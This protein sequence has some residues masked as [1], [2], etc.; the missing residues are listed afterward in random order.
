MADLNDPTLLQDQDFQAVLNAFLAAYRPFLEKESSLAASAAALIKESQA[1]PPTCDD[2]INTAVALFERFYTKDVALRVLPDEGRQVLGNPDQWEWCYRRILC[3]L[4]FG[5]L[6]CRGPRTF[7]GFAYYLYQ[8]WRC[9]RQALGQPVSVPP[10]VD[11]Q[12]DFSTLVKILAAAYAPSIQDQVKDLEYPIDIPKEIVA[13]KIDCTVDNDATTSV[14]Q[15]LCTPEASRALFGKGFEQIGNPV[16]A[17]NCCC[18]CVAALEFGCCLGRAKT[19]LEALRCLE[20]FFLNLRRCFQ[21]LIAIIDTPPACSSLTFVAA[22]SNLGGIEIDGTAAG[23]AFTSYTLSYSAGGPIINTAVVYPDCTRPPVNPS[24]ATPVNGGVLG[25]LDVDLLPPATTTVTVYLDVYGSG[26]LHL[27]VSAVYNLA[28]NAIQIT[29]VATVAATVAQDPFNPSPSIIKMVQNVSNPAFEQSVGGSISVT[30]SAYTFGCGN[31]MTQYQLAEFGPATG[32]IPLPTPSP[33]PTALGGTPLI[34]PVIYDN[35][36]AHPWSSG[37]F[38]GPA[39]PNIILNGDIVAQWSTESCLLPSPHTIPKISSNLKWA[40][41][42]SGRYVIFL[43]VDEGP[44]PSLMPVSPAGEDQVVVWIDNYPTVGAIT[45]VGNVVGCGDLHLK[46]YVGTTAAIKGIAW[47][48][49]IDVTATQQLPNDNFG[50]Y[51]LSYQKNGGSMRPFLASDYTPNGAPAGTAPTVRV[52][53][54]WQAAPPT[55]AQASL[56]ASWD[57]VTALDGGP[58]PDPNNPCVATN[59][60]QLPRG[61]RCAYVIEL[62]VGDTTWVGDGGN[63]HSTG[64]ILFAVN[65]INDIGT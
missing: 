28:I 42:A 14:F 49:P 27:Q 32:A 40:S 55:L 64:P 34:A 10:T 19:L 24:S 5:W 38:P 1:H 62:V 26:G 12:R 4:I 57:I 11:E 51:S 36:P 37:C 41:G 59:A 16:L 20:E 3:C 65:V 21:P 56:L 31:Q 46:D 47:D 43:E 15:R 17:R 54:L 61:C 39:T 7:R 22:C 63:N 48:Y 9:V 50:S 2:E 13:G 44:L 25:Y 58:P 45:Q 8:Y 35:T 29:A 33:S 60:W 52:P 30:G 23:A 18:Y 6:V 53:N